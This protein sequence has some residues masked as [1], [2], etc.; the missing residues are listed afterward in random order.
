MQNAHLCAEPYFKNKKYDFQGIPCNIDHFEFFI[1]ALISHCMR[2]EL[3]HASAFSKAFWQMSEKSAKV[4]VE[5]GNRAY[6]SL[7]LTSHFD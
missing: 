1:D 6:D 2:N 3:I 4:K 7:Q 5:I